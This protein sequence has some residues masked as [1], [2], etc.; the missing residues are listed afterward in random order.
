M[1]RFVLSHEIL[2]IVCW[3]FGA[4]GTPGYIPNPAVKHSNTDGTYIVGRVGRRQHIVLNIN[5][6]K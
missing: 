2:N 4:V 3:C 6:G 5:S 1:D